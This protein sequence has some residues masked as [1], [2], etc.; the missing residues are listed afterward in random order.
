MNP[1]R[2][3]NNEKSIIL[4]RQL[5][6]YKNLDPPPNSQVCLPLSSFEDI[7]ND[8]STPLQEALGQLTA[9]ALFFAGR[10]CEYSKVNNSESRKTKILCLRNIQFYSDYQ[11]IKNKNS[12]HQADIVQITFESQKTDV[13]NQ[14]I[15]QHSGSV[16]RPGV[17]SLLTTCTK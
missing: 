6:G 4:Q 16:E 11:E 8:N 14:P 13:K 9:G 5:C 17:S 10:S 1:Q 2:D 15:I 7:Y 3:D 12:F